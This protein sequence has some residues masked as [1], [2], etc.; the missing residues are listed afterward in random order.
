MKNTIK[1]VLRI[2]L[3]IIM[4]IQILFSCIWMVCNVNVIPL[5]GDSH[6]YIRLS[7]TFELDEYRTI[8][9]PLILRVAMKLQSWTHIPYHSIVFVGQTLLCFFC[10][11][12]VVHT[13]AKLLQLEQF[14]IVKKAF[15]SFY[16]ISIPMITFMNFAILPDS[17]A[18][19]ML[20]LIVAQCI[21]IFRAETFRWQEIVC[22]FFA[23]LAEALIRADRVYSCGLF[24]LIF[25]V[26]MLVKK[27]G[28]VFVLSSAITV[29][30]VGMIS[31]CV[32]SATQ[33]PGFYNR[34][35][36]SAAFVLL[37]RVVWPNMAANYD[38]Y[39][40]EIR[41]NI[42]L[43]EAQHF[44]EHNNNVMYY[45]APLLEERVGHARAEE[46]YKEMAGVVLRNQGG[47]VLYDITDDFLGFLFAPTTAY[48]SY[49]GKVETNNGWNL[50]CCSSKT[51]KLVDQYVRSYNLLFGVVLFIC[52]II[53]FLYRS[54]I[55]KDEKH[56]AF[57][58]L[59][60]PFLAMT[61]IISLW[62]SLG[63]GAPPNDRYVLIGHMTWAMFILGMFG[64]SQSNIKTKG[65]I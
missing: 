2:Q 56:R 4:T 23:F 47:K 53:M 60:A 41:E 58:G 55:I 15:I 30:V 17:I 11:Y 57:I 32:N 14:G 5:F 61:V 22:L 25:C 16:L 62:F 10:M 40:D 37:D 1:I 44:D 50:H 24:I 19:S 42:S 18:L 46:M 28:R 29:L 13:F 7:Q 8:L 20:C 43:E 6:E 21:R 51:P 64:V 33:K 52:A 9:Y 35:S 38:D 54:F 49:H 3:Y 34:V 48:L 39:S 36:T 65:K 59:W 12:Y 27:K 31:F 45:L 26:I 63:D